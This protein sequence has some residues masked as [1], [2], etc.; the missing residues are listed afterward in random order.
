MYA[1]CHKKNSCFPADKNV[2]CICSS[3]YAII[4][5]I[6]KP[7]LMSAFKVSNKRIL[8]FR[9]NLVSCYRL[10]CNRRYMVLGIDFMILFSEL[11]KENKNNF[12]RKLVQY[13]ESAETFFSPTHSSFIISNTWKV[14]LLLASGHSHC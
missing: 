11:R 1:C 10:L 4:N 8:V 13:S 7:S 5:Q 2:K 9:Q 6:F 3:L 12:L 14:L